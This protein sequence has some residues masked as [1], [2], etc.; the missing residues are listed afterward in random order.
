MRASAALLVVTLAGCALAPAPER[1]EV[2]KQAMPN[3]AVPPQWTAAAVPTGAVTS[4]WLAKFGDPA[5]VALVN[6]AIA[7]NLDLRAAAAR[8]EQ[9]AGYLQASGAT[10]YPQVNLLARG[11]GKAGGDSS[12]LQGIGFFATWELDLWGRVRSGQAFAR[13]QYESAQLDAEYARQ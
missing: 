6:E 8:V 12:G 4:D 10:L 7:Y 9:A 11:G 13:L 5:L 1:D 2:R 3:A